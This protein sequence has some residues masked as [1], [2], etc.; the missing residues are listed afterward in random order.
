MTSLVQ[1]DRMLTLWL[2]QAAGHSAVL[3][4]VVFDIAGA[5]I[6][7][8]GIFL[9]IYWWLWFANPA[10]RRD[11]VVALMA[12]VLVAVAAR[13]LQ[14]GLPL[15]HGPLLTPGLGMR[16]PSSVDPQ[17]LK[18]FSSFPSD[19]A[20]F[21]FALCV[22]IW[23]RSRGLGSAAILWTLLLICLPRVYLGYHYASDIIGGALIGVAL[24]LVLQLLLGRSQLPDRL[25]GLATAHPAPFYG[26]AFLVSLEIAVLFDDLR[27][28][29][30]DAMRLGKLLVG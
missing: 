15:H 5:T 27:H 29:M 1:A 3:D 2:N 24:M 22:P 11:L 19:H 18:T 14:L 9:A 16:P 7:K 25:V 30:L 21:F 8:G 10:R 28:F 26:L 20:M 6:L 13:S 17:A 23:M 4:S 12:S